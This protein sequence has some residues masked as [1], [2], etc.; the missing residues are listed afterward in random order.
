MGFYLGI[1][2]GG[3]RTECVLTDESGK[4]VAHAEGA[5]TNLGRT[6]T[7]QLEEI[8][9]A[10][11]KDLKQAAGLD[12]ADFNAVCAGFAGAG[13][14]ENRARAEEVLRKVTQPQELRVVGDMEIAL[15]AATGG[16]PGIV[17]IAGTGSIAYGRASGGRTAR[18]GG[19]GPEAG[20][21]G[22]GYAIGSA[23]IKAWFAQTA[24]GKLRDELSHEL[25]I[26][27]E[28]ELQNLVQ[29]ANAARLAALTGAVERAAEAGSRQAKDILQK[30][31]Q[32]L[33]A[34]AADVLRELELAPQEV[35]I[36]ACGGA[37]AASPRLLQAAARALVEAAPGAKL[38]MPDTLPA[39]GAARMARRLWQEK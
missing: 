7:G 9:N 33:A 34:L 14:E 23:A 38:E 30:A 25:G 35:S 3:S 15:E 27:D 11:L 12:R 19:K 28:K 22:S 24:D 13:R 21:A 26:S 39:E 37:F 20:D 10:L 16:G 2:G 32:E 18:A 36:T 31:G 17:L 1:D 29:P 4:I 8:V 6:S 5:G